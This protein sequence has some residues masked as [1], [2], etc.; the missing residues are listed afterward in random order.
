MP[1]SEDSLHKSTLSVVFPGISVHDMISEQI[2]IVNQ[3]I[4]LCYETL[5]RSTV[6]LCMYLRLYSAPV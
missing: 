1:V 3:D 2:F 4:T 6:T 5:Y